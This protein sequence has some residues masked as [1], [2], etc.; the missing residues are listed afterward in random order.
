MKVLYAKEYMYRVLFVI[1][2]EG[3]V[4][5]CYRSSGLSGTG[6]KGII[7]PFSGLED[8]VRLSSNPGYIYKEMFFCGR[9]IDHYK[10][11]SRY[12]DIEKIMS[13]IQELTKD[14]KPEPTEINSTLELAKFAK[15]INK[16]M[17]KVTKDKQSYDFCP[18]N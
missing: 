5:N 13:E 6:H 8:K 12:P 17:T 4:I 14:I 15:Q 7:L 1:E 16:E 18:T 11:L 2:R 9:Y 10:D 3:K